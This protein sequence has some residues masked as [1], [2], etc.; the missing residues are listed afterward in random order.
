MFLPS[1]AHTPAQKTLK[2][3]ID[4]VQKP[5]GRQKT[6]WVCQVLKEIKLSTNLSLKYD[7]RKNIE[8]QKPLKADFSNRGDWSS[9]TNSMMLTR[10]RNMQ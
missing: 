6:T 7:I 2:A 4:P 10:L 9:A 3:F 5:P 8:I 1:N